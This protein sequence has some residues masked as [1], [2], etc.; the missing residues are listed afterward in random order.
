VRQV[1][2]RRLSGRA[3][4]ENRKDSL[5]KKIQINR[6]NCPATQFQQTFP[7]IPPGVN[8]SAGKD[9]GSSSRHN[10]LLIPDSGPK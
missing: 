1:E 10:D 3:G 8:D 4:V 5:E 2:D 6:R 9:S 7:G